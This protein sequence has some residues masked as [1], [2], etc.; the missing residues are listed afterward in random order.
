ML[1]TRKSPPAQVV[2]QWTENCSAVVLILAYCRN[3]E[4][5]FD[6]K[7]AVGIAIRW[8]GEMNIQNQHLSGPVGRLLLAVLVGFSATM[9]FL[10][11][12]TSL[13]LAQDL[14]FPPPENLT[15]TVQSNNIVIEWVYTVEP[16]ALTYTLWRSESVSRTEAI[17]VEAPLLAATGDGEPVVAY[18]TM[19]D[20]SIQP[21]HTYTYWLDATDAQGNTA[22]FGPLSL[23]QVDDAS[24][25]QHR[26]FLPIITARQ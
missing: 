24:Q 5:N 8:G 16:T 4:I 2:V 20:S 13:A 1:T 3:Q 11:G 15:I 22:T 19:I 14:A 25:P 10:W 6:G 9:L 17:R 18:Y 12:D 21:G 7:V 26:V 23:D